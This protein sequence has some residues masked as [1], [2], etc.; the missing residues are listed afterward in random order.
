MAGSVIFLFLTVPWV[1]LQRLIVA[2]HS[3]THLLFRGGVKSVKSEGF[4]FFIKCNNSI[5]EFKISKLSIG[6]GKLTWI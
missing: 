2:L 1:D 5:I 4:V 3:H 6:A